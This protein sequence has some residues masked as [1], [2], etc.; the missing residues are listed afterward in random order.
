MDSTS[1]LSPLRIRN[2]V[3]FSVP[4]LNK[5][6]GMKLSSYPPRM[7]KSPRVPVPVGIFAI[8]T[9]KKAWITGLLFEGFFYSFDKRMNGR[10]Y[11]LFVNN[12]LAHPKV[13]EG[14]SNVELFFLS[15]N[16]TPKIQPYNAEIIRGL[17]IQYRRCFFSS[18]LEDYRI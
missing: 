10:K 14:L 3:N 13:I 8:P 1:S 2:W 9:N 11:L 18:I 17:K 6:L 15:P 5:K 16:T 12:Y 7:G 4:F